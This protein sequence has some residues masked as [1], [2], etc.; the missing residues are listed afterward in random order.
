MFAN[1]R[2]LHECDVLLSAGRLDKISCQEVHHFKPFSNGDNGA[3]TTLSASLMFEDEE[4]GHTE[5]STD[6]GE[7]VKT[8]LLF[9]HD[10]QRA[11][12][13][14]DENFVKTLFINAETVEDNEIPTLFNNLVYSLRNMKHSQLI[15]IYHEISKDKS[16]GKSLFM[17]ALPLL[18]TDAG[19]SLM[20]DIIMTGELPLK[21]VDS[22]L[23]SL[24]FYKNPTR[25]MIS[26]L[27]TLVNT[28]SSLSALLGI[29]G[30]IKT[31][32][33]SV[34][35]CYQMAEVREIMEKYEFQ[36]GNSCETE[37]TEDEEH[38]TVILKSIRNIGNITNKSVI[39]KCYQ[40]KSNSI[41]VRL[42]ALDTIRKFSC[43]F[44]QSDFGLPRLFRDKQED[45]ELRIGAY[46][47]LVHCPSEATIDNIKAVM[48]DEPINQIGSFVWTHLTNLQ[49]TTSK[50]T[51]KMKLKNIVGSD[52]I[53]NKWNTDPR[54]FSRNI[55]ISYHSNDLRVGGTLDS[56]IIF[57]EKSY[58]PRSATV[59]ITTNLFGENINLLEFG[60][61]FE[62][63]EDTVEDF[64]GPEGYFREDNIH[65]L[66]QNLRTKRDVNKES[67]KP[68]QQMFGPEARKEEPRGNVYIRLFGMDIH[69]NSFQGIPALFTNMLMKPLDYLGFSFGDN[70]LEF[71]KSS[72]FLDGC[73]VVPTVLGLP[74]NL[75]V[76]GTSHLNVKSRT[77]L[78]FSELF[79]SGKAHLKAQIY[80]NIAL[81]I[82]ALMSVD[83]FFAKTGLK[84][85]SKLHSS[86]Y[87][88]AFADIQN[89]K[90]IKLNI[91][92]PTE[93]I[94]LVEASADFLTYKEGE[95]HQLRTLGAKE[96]LEKC[97]SDKI[98]NLLGFKICA[99]GHYYSGNAGS[100]PEWY[101][102]GSSFAAIYLKKIDSLDRISVDY[103][104]S[105][106]DSS[107]GKGIMDDIRLVLDTPGSK[108]K[109]GFFTQLKFDNIK[110]F[111]LIEID[112]PVWNTHMELR[113]D[114][115]PMKKTIKGSLTIEGFDI[116]VLSMQLEKQDNKYE[117]SCNLIYWNKE[118]VDWQ[119]TV[120][121][122]P[123]KHSLDAT[124]K[125]SFHD[126][127]AIAGDFLVQQNNINLSANLTSNVLNINFNGKCHLS[128]TVFKI[129][130]MMMYK[131]T[132][133][134]AGTLDLSAKVQTAQ[135]GLLKKQ[136]VIITCKVSVKIKYDQNKIFELPNSQSNC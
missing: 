112:F 64:F 122:V 81:E 11:D 60:G 116:I 19:V 51:W 71:S 20:R 129:T 101:F 73:I 44:S 134:Y 30:I 72:I 29:S 80:P 111:F 1:F 118:I 75:T 53:Q 119:G 63:F 54:K 50:D 28:K 120:H 43:Q 45:S 65:K 34:E 82:S 121:T 96:S 79:L 86:A 89:G 58:L 26:I 5:V 76:N 124:L 40:N 39:R 74:L 21:I 31:F 128:E 36:L 85:V 115:S 107:P 69:Y 92:L 6:S 14:A 10:H 12:E 4:E 8:N 38:L 57:S 9:V 3:T 49:E 113:Y 13:S 16:K 70:E 23:F 97:S 87:I 84:S 68:L 17:D 18:K 126:P 24:T 131:I 117:A 67:M 95:F 105:R 98:A 90:L 136:N 32:C 27:T 15:K 25:A 61:R 135:Q 130:G 109:R 55:E 66:L 7:K 37:T 127:I 47:V 100:S 99:E 133:K 59:N 56:N 91:N 52:F 35:N 93:K 33:Q 102:T 132:E 83:A 22:W 88:D 106:D 2:S 108:M 77:K 125:G 46:L 42:A 78:K 114:W 48:I 123:N 94:E 104:W 41:W 62:G 110:T 103:S